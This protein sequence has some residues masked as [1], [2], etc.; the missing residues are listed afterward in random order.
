MENLGQNKNINSAIILMNFENLVLK[1]V[2]Y[3]FHEII[4]TEDFNFDK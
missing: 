4:K 1:I 3:Y 2:C